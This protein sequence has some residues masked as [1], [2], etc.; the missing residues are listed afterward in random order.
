MGHEFLNRFFEN[1]VVD[2]TDQTEILDDPYELDT[3]N[4][5]PFLVAHPQ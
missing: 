1:M 3:S 2:Q 4:N 5:C